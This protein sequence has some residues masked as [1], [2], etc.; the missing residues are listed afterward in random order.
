MVAGGASGASAGGEV[1]ARERHRQQHERRDAQ[2]QQQQVAQPAAFVPFDRRL[3]QHL[4]GR[5]VHDLVGPAPEEMQ[6]DGNRHGGDAGEEHGG[7]EAEAEHRQ[8][9]P[10]AE[11]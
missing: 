11:R 3:R 2:R 6:E 10:R 5:E 7:E 9:R 4:R 1:R 8:L